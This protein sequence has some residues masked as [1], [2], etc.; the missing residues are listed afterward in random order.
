MRSAVRSPL[1]WALALLVAGPA[2][3]ADTVTFNVLLT[4]N[5]ACTITAASATNVN[6]GNADPARPRR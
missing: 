2:T 3:A 1:A 5:K 4:I 6:F